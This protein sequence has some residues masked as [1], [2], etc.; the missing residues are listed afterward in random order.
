MIF[1][2]KCYICTGNKPLPVSLA[3]WFCVSLYEKF[4]KGSYQHCHS[5]F[6]L[7][8][9]D[10]FEYICYTCV[11]RVERFFLFLRIR[12]YFFSFSFFFSI[13]MQVGSFGLKFFCVVNNEIDQ[14]RVILSQKMDPKSVK[15]E[16][17]N[18]ILV[19]V[20]D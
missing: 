15:K 13:L 2:L 18:K 17:N 3:I 14:F 19:N 1:F 12:I 7:V 8:Q 4:D 20:H 10:L 6:F 11:H 16:Q 9:L 5:F